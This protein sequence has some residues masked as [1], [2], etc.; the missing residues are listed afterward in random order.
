MASGQKCLSNQNSIHFL[1]FPE[2]L[3]IILHFNLNMHKNVK[4][5]SIRTR[6][7]VFLIHFENCIETN[8]STNFHIIFY[9]RMSVNLILAKYDR[10]YE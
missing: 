9:E 8:L 4:Y 1:I 3:S 5:V 6:R 10:E 7:N 2:V